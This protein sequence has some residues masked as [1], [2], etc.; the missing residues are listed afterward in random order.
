MSIVNFGVLSVRRKASTA[1]SILLF[2]IAQSC[3]YPKYIKDPICDSV[4]DYNLSK[5]KILFLINVANDRSYLPK[6]DNPSKLKRYCFGKYIVDKN[7]NGVY[8]FGNSAHIEPEYIIMSENVI[9]LINIAQ[10]HIGVKDSID[11]ALLFHGSR[12]DGKT[13]ALIIKKIK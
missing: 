6:S 13:R 9:S 2:L 12:I 10:G 5:E 8:Y 3:A 7:G 4:D 1:L 11:K